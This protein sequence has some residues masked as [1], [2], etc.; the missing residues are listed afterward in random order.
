MHCL[1]KSIDTVESR[2]DNVTNAPTFLSPPPLS[3]SMCV[4]VGGEVRMSLHKARDVYG[5]FV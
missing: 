4:R 1:L 3:P 5:M 2:W